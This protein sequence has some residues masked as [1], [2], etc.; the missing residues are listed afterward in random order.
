[1]RAA[2]TSF[3]LLPNL[4]FA[5][6]PTCLRVYTGE[7]VPCYSQTK[8]DEAQAILKRRGKFVDKDYI[9]SIEMNR[10]TFDSARALADWIY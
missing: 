5:E 1:M 10:G 9:I 8:I 6:V 4:A 7:K 3:I 2:L